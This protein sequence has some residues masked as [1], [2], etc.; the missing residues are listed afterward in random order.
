[1]KSLRLLTLFLI[2]SL[3]P[4]AQELMEY[5]HAA[6]DIPKWPGILKI[7]LG[8]ILLGPI[9]PYGSAYGLIYES[10]IAEKQSIQAGVAILGRGPVT[11][12]W[13][14]TGA[15][16]STYVVKGMELQFEYKFYVSRRKSPVPRG[17]Y[18]AP[19]FHFTTAQEGN[20]YSAQIKGSDIAMQL[21]D[22][23]LIW[24][25]QMMRKNGRGLV[26]DFFAGAGYKSF[27]AIRNLAPGYA[28][29]Y[30]G[31]GKLYTEPLNL[32]IGINI[33]W[34]RCQKDQN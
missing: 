17:W 2:L 16:P 1:L 5:N 26:I 20:L 23:N 8:E 12:V 27:A 9:P 33:G 13:I 19:L 10:K 34:A 14:Q 11:W 7:S 24:G 15:F 31:F 32:L 25:A 21:F 28:E 6:P 4:Y 18:V 22:V 29:P 3:S 30:P